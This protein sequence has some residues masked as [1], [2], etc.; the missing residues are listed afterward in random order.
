MSEKKQQVNGDILADQVKEKMDEVRTETEQREKF[1]DTMFTF[2]LDG[3]QYYNSEEKERVAQNYSL[4]A[5]NASEDYVEEYMARLFP[6]N[7]KTG[8]IEV[9]VKVFEEKDD[10]RQKYEESILDCYDENFLIEILLEQGQNF[11]VGGA[12]CFFYPPDS[13]GGATI[14]SLDPKKVFLGWSGRRLKW[15]GYENETDDEIIFV[16]AK[17]TVVLDGDYKFKSVEE[18]KHGFIPFSWIPS[19]PKAH[20]KEGR[21]KI[22][23]LFDLDREINFRMSDFSKRAEDNTEP[24]RTV[25]SNDADEDKIKRGKGKTTVLSQGDKMENLELKEGQELLNY[26]N[27][28]DEKINK[29]TGVVDTA[30]TIKSAVSGLSLSFQY[31]SMLDKIGFMRVFWDRAFRE[32]NRAI[33][34]YAHGPE[35]SKKSSEIKNYRTMPVYQPAIIHDSKQRV[36]EYKMMLEM[37]VISRRDVIDELRGVENSEDKLKEIEDEQK[38]DSQSQAESD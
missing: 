4:L 31:S 8:A 36:E 20:T 17:Q 33:L 16:T 24:H 12:G 32:M 14:M 19:F 37:G 18:N 7:Q 25:Y 13:F 22:N 11:L 2:V 9:G 35:F 26:I 3:S 30:G 28:V 15:F 29:K 5:F 21:S 27:K 10:L 6:R 23:S 1:F 38:K 34:T